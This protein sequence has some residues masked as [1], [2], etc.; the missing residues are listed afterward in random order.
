MKALLILTAAFL[1]ASP[2]RAELRTFKNTKGE[3]IKAE[4]IGATDSRV[5]LKREDGKKFSVPLTTLSEADR[6]WVAEWRKKHKQ[7]KV[8]VVASIKRGISRVEKGG[9]FGG[10]D[11]KGNDCWYVLNFSNKTTDPLS[12]LRIEYIIFAPAG[13]AEP[14]LCGAVDVPV[15]PPGKAGQAATGKLF[16]EQK[17]TVLRAGNQSTVSFSEASLAGIHAELIV[18]GK[19]AGTFLSGNV[20]A[21]AGPQLQQWRDKQ[22]QGEAPKEKE[23]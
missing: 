14:S 3:E 11:T 6:Q 2:L 4:M 23:P 10:K 22:K 9:A 18:A 15:I 17:Q 7:Y 16:A 5:E 21:D 13:A 12:D 20:P 19:P 1:T 8:E